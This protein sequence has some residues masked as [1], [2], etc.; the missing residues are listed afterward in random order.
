MEEFFLIINYS[1]IIRDIVLRIEIKFES[2]AIFSEPS[3]SRIKFKK[4]KI[5]VNFSCMFM[6]KI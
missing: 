3:S 4:D 2:E 6:W 5:K 1:R